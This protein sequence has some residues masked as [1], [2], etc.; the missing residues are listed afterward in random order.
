M[1][2]RKKD[3]PGYAE[4][5]EQYALC[6]QSQLVDYSIVAFYTPSLFGALSRAYIRVDE[7]STCIRA[8]CWNPIARKHRSV[9]CP[10]NRDRRF[11]GFPNLP[12]DLGFRL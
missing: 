5:R 2:P 1:P 6:D 9:G 3:E 4:Y 7:A 11:G 10:L 12:V 8:D